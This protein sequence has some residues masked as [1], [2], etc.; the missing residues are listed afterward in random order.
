MAK[1]ENRQLYRI[2]DGS[3]TIYPRSAPY[4]LYEQSVT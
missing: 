2:V 3:R 1:A 4:I